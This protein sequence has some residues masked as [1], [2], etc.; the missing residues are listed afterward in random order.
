MMGGAIGYKYNVTENAQLWG[1]TYI[2]LVLSES[3][4][5][6]QEELE[7]D[8]DQDHYLVEVPSESLAGMVI[9][10][11]YEAF[12]YTRRG[13]QVLVVVL[14]SEEDQPATPTP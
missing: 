7:G 3:G 10:V 5:S 14:P 11:E 12:S 4:A 8:T 2:A 9:G 1:D 13:N 6:K